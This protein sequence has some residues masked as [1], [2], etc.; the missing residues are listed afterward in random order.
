M[1]DAAFLFVDG[2]FFF[3]LVK[4]LAAASRHAGCFMDSLLLVA[5]DVMLTQANACN[6][7][8]KAARAIIR[9]VVGWRS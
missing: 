5:A 8:Q 6:A 4:V 2:S 7:M 9:D 3:V 1:N